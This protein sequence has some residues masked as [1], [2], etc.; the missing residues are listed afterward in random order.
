MVNPANW[1]PMPVDKVVDL[2]WPSQIPWWVAGGWAI[3]LFLGRQTRKHDDIDILILRHDQ[4]HIQKHLNEWELFKTNQ[5]GLAPWERGEI[6]SAPVNCFWARRD[7]DSP[8]SFEVMLMDTEGDHWV[9]RREPTIRGHLSQIGLIDVEG[10]PYLRPEIQ[11]LYKSSSNRSKDFDDLCNV[12]PEL[13]P[14]SKSWLLCSLRKQHNESHP[15]IE[16][17]ERSTKQ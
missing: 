1:D 10:V 13:E 9:Y 16:Y 11:L 7:K 17:I 5:P 6:L 3:D 2:L 4:L 8:W 14:D 15:W 12:L